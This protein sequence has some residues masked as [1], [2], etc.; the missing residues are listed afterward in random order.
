MIYR[1]DDEMY[2]AVS[3]TLR[4]SNNEISHFLASRRADEF[5]QASSL[6]VV[7]VLVSTFPPRALNLA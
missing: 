1:R 5:R 7:N 6:I 4:R 2:Q 3:D